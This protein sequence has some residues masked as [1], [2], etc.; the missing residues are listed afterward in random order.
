MSRKVFGILMALTLALLMAVAC[1]PKTTPTPAPPTKPVI[2]PTTPPAV[3]PEPTKTPEPFTLTMWDIYPQ[4]QPSRAVLDNA[5]KRFNEKYPYV[6]VEVTSYAIADFKTK[7]VTALAADAA[8]DIFQTW[9]GGTLF[10]YGARG[11]AADLTPYYLADPAFKDRFTSAALSFVTSPDGKIYGVPLEVSPVLF[12]Y[13]TE[14]F[15]KHGVSVPKTFD[16]LLGACATFNKAGIAPISL[17][18]SKATWT[19]DFFYVYLVNRVGGMEVFRKAALRE[20]GGT[21]EDPAFVQAGRLLQQM[22][23]ARCFQ[24]G[25]LGAEYASQ[26]QLLGQEKAAMTLMG[27]WLPGQMAKEFPEVYPKLDYFLFPL[28][29]GG[30]GTT[31]QLVGG[32]N[33]A[34]AMSARNK[35]PEETMALFKEFASVATADDLVALARRLPATKYTFDPAKVDALTIRAAME[36]EKASAV[37][38]YYDQYLPPDMATAHLDI[39]AALFA[40]TTT[41]EQAAKDTEA[42]AVRYLK[43]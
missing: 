14:L 31:S 41:P 29:S 24:D 38:L 12:F 32:T 10:T 36:L 22:V 43:K 7:L 39:T 8:P 25:F 5:I 11:Q 34:F 23:D 26:R 33:L 35:H 6:K 13:N 40:K 30:A 19:G 4:G 16:E 9:G 20:A 27:T 18:M 21:F 37:Q 3:S 17:A 1:G 2:Q 15:A 28:V 42:A